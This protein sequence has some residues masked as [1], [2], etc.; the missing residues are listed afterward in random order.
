MMLA[1]GGNRRQREADPL[2]DRKSKVNGQTA[3][4]LDLLRTTKEKRLQYYSQ[5]VAKHE[6]IKYIRD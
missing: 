4:T 2:Y 3:S 1:I 5:Q 6:P